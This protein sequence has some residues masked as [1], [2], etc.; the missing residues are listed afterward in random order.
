MQPDPIGQDVQAISCARM[1]LVSLSLEFMEATVSGDR[2]GAEAILGSL[3]PGEWVADVR[4]LF[5]RRIEQ[6]RVDPRE[7]EWLARA[8]LLRDEGRTVA[9]HIGFHGPPDERGAVEVGY[10]VL[11]PFRRR[12]YAHEAVQALFDWAGAAHGITL[13]VASVG[14][15]NTPSLGLVRRLGFVQTGARWDEIDGQELVFEL[16]RPASE[17]SPTRPSDPPDRPA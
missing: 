3:I 13:F 4:G 9:G 5:R 14:P 15:W 10:T 12:G 16:R 11:E 8:M 17:N 6:V 2:A 1:D 7:Q